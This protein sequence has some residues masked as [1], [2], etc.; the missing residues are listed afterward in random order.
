MQSTVIG[1][2]V[3]NSYKYYQQAYRLVTSLRAFGGK[4][5]NTDV[6]ICC[7]NSIDE[8]FSKCIETFPNVE[9]RVCPP[10][11]PTRRRPYMNKFA[12]FKLEDLKN[13]D[14]CILLDCD[15]L[16]CQDFSSLLDFEKVK[17]Q[18]YSPMGSS[19]SCFVKGNPY[20]NN[21][22]YFDKWIEQ[23][24]FS[25]HSILRKNDWSFS[26]PIGPHRKSECQFGSKNV[27]YFSAI[28]AMICVPKK[29]FKFID[30]LLELSE[31]YLKYSQWYEDSLITESTGMEGIIAR[32][33]L[34]HYTDE[35]MLALTAQVYVLDIDVISYDK[36]YTS[37]NGFA[38]FV[39]N[40]QHYFNLSVEKTVL[41]VRSLPFIWHCPESFYTVPR[42]N[43]ANQVV[44]SEEEAKSNPDL[45]TYVS[46]LNSYL[47]H[48]N[49]KFPWVVQLSVEDAINMPLG[50]V[51]V[52]THSPCKV[53]PK[54][55]LMYE[56][57]PI[58][59]KSV[60]ISTPDTSNPSISSLFPQTYVYKLS[61]IE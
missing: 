59:C 61:L 49:T 31:T 11:D 51:G 25:P 16:V 19:I 41:G 48:N 2:V 5:K 54:N 3:D 4:M 53:V 7:I 46:V 8:S 26:L 14:L 35:L 9:L 37:L 39:S 15:T 6:I 32:G 20:H 17:L 10:I 30:I 27:T 50:E 55:H 44:M 29:Q 22:K 47:E 43:Y 33:S 45:L 42:I 1:C 24:F 28:G 12:F 58:K 56:H 18:T 60:L 57:T 36:F 40:M 34:K 13:Y 52:I 21:P 23:Q 38:K